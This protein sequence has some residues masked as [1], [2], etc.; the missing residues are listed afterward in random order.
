MT[1]LVIE[2]VKVFSNIVE[3]LYQ[4]DDESKLK[5]FDKKLIL[6]SEIEV[7]TDI[8]G[9]NVNTPALLKTVYSNLEKQLIEK[10][11]IRS[12]FE[13]LILDLEDLIK[14]E[15]ID[16]DLDL[17]IGE[18]TIQQI[19]KVFGVRVEVDNRTIF[20]KITEIIKVFKYQ[21]KK[22]LLIFIN[23][24]SYLDS[25]EIVQLREYISLYHLNV[26]FLEPKKIYGI[27]Q[28]ILDK[29]YYLYRRNAI[30]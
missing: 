14:E 12:I 1:T 8:L 25:V 3:M 18:V 11:E 29:D 30:I 6:N 23:V 7:V 20:E 24:C 9:Y 2:D 13:N 22:K 4:Y 28:Y 26:L 15:F 5:I 17:E 16:Y 27:N 10:L 21:I 19:F